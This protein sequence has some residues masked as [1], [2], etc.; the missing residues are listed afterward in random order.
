M[1]RFSPSYHFHGHVH[2]QYVPTWPRVRQYGATTVVN[3][4]GKYFVELPD[5]PAPPPGTGLRGW[6]TRRGSV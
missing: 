5:R 2:L 6:W 1:D 3:A 4:S